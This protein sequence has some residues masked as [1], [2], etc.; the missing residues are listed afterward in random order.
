MKKPQAVP[1]FVVVDAVRRAF[2]AIGGD[3][4]AAAAEGG[5]SWIDSEDLADAVFSDV[6]GAAPKEWKA[7]PE[8]DRWAA[9]K[10]ATRSLADSR[11]RIHL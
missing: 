3:L 1:A 10:A 5:A 9:V 2:R 11:K 8:R 4:A 7:L 6:N